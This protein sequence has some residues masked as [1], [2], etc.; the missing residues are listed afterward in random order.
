MS[1]GT[2]ESIRCSPGDS[3]SPRGA[4][5]GRP[6]LLAEGCAISSASAQEFPAQ[7]R[8]AAWVPRT[9]AGAAGPA[10]IT[11]P[12]SACKTDRLRVFFQ[13]LSQV[14]PRQESACVVARKA[15]SA[16]VYSETCWRAVVT[17]RPLNAEFR[18]TGRFPP[19]RRPPCRQ[20]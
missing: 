17:T 16:F 1:F 20:A 9:C 18:S 10:L 7:Q 2:R 13:V 11:S 8:G 15:H 5:S 14:P 3:G 4:R 6:Q 19:V 12:R